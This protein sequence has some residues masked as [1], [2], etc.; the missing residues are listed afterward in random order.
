MTT[1][2]F[3]Y[4][5]SSIPFV[6]NHVVLCP[7]KEILLCIAVLYLD[8]IQLY[9]KTQIGVR[10]V[11]LSY[12][13]RD[14]DAPA[15]LSTLAPDKPYSTTNGS[16]HDELVAHMPHDGIG[17]DEDATPKFLLFFCQYSRPVPM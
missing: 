16:F 15:A 17:F 9:L 4:Y 12:V 2:Y 8:Q 3:Y 13:I 7:F 5:F 10:G 11:P 6:A 14:H 1:I